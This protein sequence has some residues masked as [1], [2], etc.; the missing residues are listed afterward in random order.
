VSRRFEA[1]SESGLT[2]RTPEIAGCLLVPAPGP[3]FTFKKDLNQ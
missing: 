1:L 2:K 3:S